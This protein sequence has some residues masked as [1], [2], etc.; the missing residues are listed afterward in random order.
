MQHLAEK[1]CDLMSSQAALVSDSD[2]L[3]PTH[4]EV[5]R[6]FCNNQ[7]LLQSTDWKPQFTLTT[8]LEE[9]IAWFRDNEGN[10]KPELYNV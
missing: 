3:R 1:I 4:S 2:R 10:Y 9:T 8:G 7:K 6:L 5:D